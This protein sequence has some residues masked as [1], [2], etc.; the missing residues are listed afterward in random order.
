[1][2]N[3]ILRGL[4]NSAAW[5][6]ATKATRALA[7]G[8]LK[9]KDLREATRILMGAGASELLDEVEPWKAH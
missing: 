6:T 9:T 7:L 8:A 3:K 5:K 2:K 1:M 4:M